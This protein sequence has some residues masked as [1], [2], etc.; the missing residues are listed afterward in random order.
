MSEAIRHGLKKTAFFRV[1][2]SGKTVDGREITAE[3]I[4]Q[5][6]STYDPETYGARVNIEHIRGYMVDSEFKMYGDVIALKAE[7]ITINGEQRR[8]L[9]AQFAVS[10]GL[11]EINQ[12]SQ[13]IYSSIEMI[14]NFAGT[15]KAYCIGLAV[16]D[17]PASLGTEALQFSQN[18][19]ITTFT[20]DAVEAELSFES[21]IVD[22][23]DAKA[24]PQVGP[25]AQE[26]FFSNLVK[27]LFKKKSAFD[28]ADLEQAFTQIAD[29]FGKHDAERVAQFTVLEEKYNALEK[30]QKALSD[31]LDKYS[32]T[33]ATEKFTAPKITG[34]EADV[35][36]ANF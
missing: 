2:V 13:K 10:E 4:D 29:E 35:E 23:A 22:K 1:A 5:M 7:D 3:Q 30:S 21:G 12:K 27:N 6:A 19:N 14:P 11:I 28:R 34:N 31:K 15:E 32:T 18:F 20:T 36:A 26:N 16:T 25:E 9:Y 33:P 8:G 24:D 17:S